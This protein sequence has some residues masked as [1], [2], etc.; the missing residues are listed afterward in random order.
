MPEQI[1]VVTLPPQLLEYLKYLI[2]TYSQSGIQVEELSL[3]AALWSRV[4]EAQ[5]LDT[6]TKEEGPEVVNIPGPVSLVHSGDVDLR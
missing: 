5:I 1:A 6:P 2:Q 3:A 4:K